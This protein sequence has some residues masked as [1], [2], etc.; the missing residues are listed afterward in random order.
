MK[1]GELG[2]K[3]RSLGHTES[4][5]ANHSSRSQSCGPGWREQVLRVGGHQHIV[6]TIIGFDKVTKGKSR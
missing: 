3:T 6:A 4:A 1:T 2:G 5:M